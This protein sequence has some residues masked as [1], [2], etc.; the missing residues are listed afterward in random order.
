MLLVD[1]NRRAPGI[2]ARM[3]PSRFTERKSATPTGDGDERDYQAVYLIGLD[4]LDQSTSKDDMKIAFGGIQTALTRFEGQIRGDEKYFDG[5]SC[6]VAASVVNKGDLHAGDLRPDTR[7]LAGEG[8]YNPGEDIEDS[9]S[10]DEEEEELSGTEA[11]KPRKKSA[12]KDKQPT[13]P[14]LPPGQKFRTASDVINRIR[15]DPGMDSA[16]YIVGYED[17][18]VGARERALDAWKTEQTDEEFIPQHRILYFKRRGEGEGS[19]GVIVWERKTRRDLVFGSG[20]VE[21]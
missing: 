12:K 16:E 11:I 20:I 5:K 18:F 8:E 6:W 14:I 1:M 21:E 15:W 4:K 7:E 2:Y 9:S 10:E 19:E 17:R 3:W 13:V